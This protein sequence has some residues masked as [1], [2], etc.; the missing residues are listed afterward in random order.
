MFAIFQSI[1]RFFTMDET[2]ERLNWNPLSNC[3]GSCWQVY[4][5]KCQNMHYQI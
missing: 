2:I 1:V 4:K 3:M 5:Y